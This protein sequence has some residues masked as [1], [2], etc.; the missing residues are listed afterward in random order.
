M[1]KDSR[2]INAGTNEIYRYGNKAQEKVK[3][4]LAPSNGWYS[5]PADGGK[6]W[7]IGTSRGKYG[8]YAKLFDTCFSVN[9]RGFVYAKEGTEK[10]ER[11]LAA[12]EALLKHMEATKAVKSYD[13]N[14]E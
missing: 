5:I 7:T 2:Y 10:A 1:F 12:I 9:S 4:F 6:Y 8:E 13:L 14:A 3:A 11:L